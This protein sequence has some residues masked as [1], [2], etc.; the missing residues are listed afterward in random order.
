[1]FSF[2]KK[3]TGFKKLTSIFKS[4]KFD[5]E[6]LS[7]LSDSLYQ[8]DVGTTTTNFLVDKIRKNKEE[9]ISKDMNIK[10]FLKIEMMKIFKQ[11]QRTL[12]LTLSSKQK[13]TILFIIGTNGVGKTTTISKLTNLYKQQGRNIVLAACD[14]TRAAAVS[15]LK[16]WAERTET[17]LISRDG[18]K[19]EVDRVI[20]DSVQFCKQ[21]PSYNLLM[22][23]T[24][25]RLQNSSV[26][27]SDLNRMLHT[28]SKSRKGAPDFVWL[29]LDSTIGQNSLQQ[30]KEFKKL[31]RVNGIIL[32]KMD[33]TAKGGIILAIANELRI[34]ICY[35]T[36]GEQINDIKAFDP[37]EFIDS[38]LST[39]EDVED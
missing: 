30:A 11:S 6:T 8:A 29:V 2:L 18:P 7:K 16:T 35:V 32:T 14:L 25:G 33:G 9:L 38:I 4:N 10:D 28:T 31:A 1:M 12:D 5:E 19:G 15:Q 23:D 26:N 3:A 20:Y 22:V 37:E 17:K 39:N 13:P 24:A 36:N 27:M 34:P 21:N